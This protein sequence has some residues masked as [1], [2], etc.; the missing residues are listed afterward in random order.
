MAEQKREIIIGAFTGTAVLLC[1]VGITWMF[2]EVNY[3][4]PANWFLAAI[5][6][7]LLGRMVST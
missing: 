6:F 5:A 2:E 4:E 3:R 7:L 1:G